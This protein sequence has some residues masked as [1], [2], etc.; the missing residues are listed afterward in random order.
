MSKICSVPVPG[1]GKGWVKMYVFTKKGLA[2]IEGTK[3][4]RE[5]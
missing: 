4:D 1:G 3:E 5:T 2:Y